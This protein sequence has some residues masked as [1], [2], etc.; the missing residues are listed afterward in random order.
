MRHISLIALYVGL[1]NLLGKRSTALG[2]FPSG[3][4]SVP[5]LAARREAMS[6]LPAVSAGRPLADELGIADDVHDALGHAIWHV[7]EA[8][9]QHPNAPADIVSAAKKVRAAFV[10][11]LDDLTSSYAAE[12]KAALD[13]MP[14]LTAL[15]NELESFPV[16]GGQTLFQWAEEF[17]AAGQKIDHLLDARADVEQKNRKAATTLRVE[18]IGILNRLRKN[19]TL[20][21]KDNPTLPRD[22]EGRVFGYLDLLEKTCADARAKGTEVTDIPATPADDETTP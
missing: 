12:A 8:Y 5:A 13:R 16:A 2:Q 17:V 14:S 1:T 9:L 22:L 15:K 3:I 20:E 7:T 21:M 18:V 4:A 19:L 6:K 11:T 10:P